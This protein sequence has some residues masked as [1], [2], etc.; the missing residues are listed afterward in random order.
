MWTASVAFRVRRALQHSQRDTARQYSKS[1]HAKKLAGMA[2]IS[3]FCAST[4][5]QYLPFERR[6][7]VA[8]LL[9]LTLILQSEAG[10]RQVSRL[11]IPCS[12]SIIVVKGGPSREQISID[13][14]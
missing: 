1:V 10:H 2:N 6:T 4:L 13:V 12:T 9:L 14:V 8:F 5:F 11:P 3:P 7:Y